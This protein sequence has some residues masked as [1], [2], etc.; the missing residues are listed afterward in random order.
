MTATCQRTVTRS[1]D[2]AR[3]QPGS[4]ADWAQ[5]PKLPQQ[6]GGLRAG[7]ASELIENVVQVK[8]N[9]RLLDA[10]NVRNLGLASLPAGVN[11]GVFVKKA[12][13][14]VQVGA[15]TTPSALFPGQTAVLSIA[16]DPTKATQTD[17][18]YAKL[19]IDP[20]NPTFHECNTMND[21][22]ADVKVMCAM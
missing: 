22:S 9:G 19:I 15:G 4:G 12:G 17:T 8:A 11:V 14:D 6:S 20:M 3:R 18:F 10:D 7:L 13:G 2:G 16:V 1:P 21:Q 5:Q